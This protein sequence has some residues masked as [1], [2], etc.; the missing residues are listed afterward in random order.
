LTYMLMNP[1]RL[2]SKSEL[3]REVWPGVVVT[4]NS[5]V[6]CVT[7]IRRE[8][9]ADRGAIETIARR[10]YWLRST[11][12]DVVEVPDFAP[13]T[14]LAQSTVPSL[15]L[16]A[17][18]Q[19][20]GH[21]RGI[22]AVFGVLLLLGGA[23]WRHLTE[24]SAAHT[25]HLE[26]APSLSMALLPLALNAGDA[27]QAMFADQVADAFTRNLSQIPGVQVVARSST[28]G[29][30]PGATN[31]RRAGRELNVHYIVEGSVERVEGQFAVD[32]RLIDVATGVQ[33]W[34]D[35]VDMSTAIMSVDP[36][37]VAG[38]LAQLL[39]A[40]LVESEIAR[41][42]RK[43]PR[44][45]DANDLAL[46]AWLLWHR[47]NAEDNAQAQVLA[48][49]AIALEPESLLAWR[50]LAG[51][52]MLDRVAAWTDD[53]EGAL[54]RAEA[55]VRRA[56]TINPR[57]PQINT[58][59]GAIMAVRGRYVEALAAFDAAQALGSSHD[60]QVHEW[61]GVT[62][63][64]MGNPGR[65]FKPL[66]TAIWLSPRDARLSYLWRTL[67]IAHMHAGDLCQGRESAWSAVRTPRPSLRAYETLAAICTM[68]G[69][70]DC[71]KGALAELLRVAPNYSMAQ[72]TKEVS[73]TEPAFVARREQYLA[74]LRTAG[75][76]Q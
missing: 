65:A 21:W 45:F 51:S 12:G 31:P 32:L 44:S 13:K 38:R 63:V 74:A 66:E 14:D 18:R 41:L 29:Y 25:S 7:E 71:A 48:R 8:L 68:Y 62:Y 61:M 26:Q 22:V 15:P 50:V 10:G 53:P 58:I 9:G 52:I 23:Y 70:D 37:D 11:L 36:R 39:K 5:L 16:R 6:Q 19:L 72:V 27:G 43:S 3:L 64:L 40:N 42:D 55:A 76:P 17:G 49:Q 24:S 56:L 4:E 35:R 30:Q 28:I 75:L 73:S 57:Q 60:P 34:S 59:L 46:R 67:A 33:Q 20:T 1:D 47:D 54:E 69:D 2:I